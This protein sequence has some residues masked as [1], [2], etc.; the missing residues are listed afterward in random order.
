MRTEKRNSQPD[1]TAQK[2]AEVPRKKTCQLQACRMSRF[3]AVWFLCVVERQVDARVLFCHTPN[4][5]TQRLEGASRLGWSCSRTFTMSLLARL[6][7]T[8]TDGGPVRPKSA[9]RN[10]PYVRTIRFAS[11]KLSIEK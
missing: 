8:T 9:N 11:S 2:M 10:S 1:E 7:T 4:K 6:S 5:R 3:V